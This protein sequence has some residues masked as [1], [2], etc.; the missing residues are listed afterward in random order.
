[1]GGHASV[2]KKKYNSMLGLVRFGRP[3][4]AMLNRRLNAVARQ[5][6][7]AMPNRRWNAVAKQTHAAMP[8]SIARSITLCWVRLGWASSGGHA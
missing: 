7:A 8:K 5:T 1:M 6:H 2:N 3:L 4:A